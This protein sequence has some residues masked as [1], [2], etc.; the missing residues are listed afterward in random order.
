M[1]MAITDETNEALPI[2]GN[3]KTERWLHRVDAICSHWGDYINPILVKETRQALKSRQ[4]VFTFSLLLFAALAWTI[5][6]SLSL[7]PNIYTSPSAARML[8]G[9]Y[10]VLAIPML[11]VVPLA[12]YRSLEVEIDDGTLE[13]LT[14][15]TLSPRQIVQGKLGS[16]SLQM[17]LYFVALFPC[18]AYAYTLRGIDL[19]TVGLL[20][21]IL[22]VS[23]LF[24]TSIA[25]SMAPQA[26]SRSGRITTLL[27]V[28]GL[29]ILAEYAVGALCVTL[30]IY[31]NPLPLDATVYTTVAV[32]LVAFAIGNLMMTAAAA[33]LTPESEN[34]STKL[35]LALVWLTMTVIGV[36]AYAVW[37]FDRDS[38]P[39]ILIASV[40]LV[41]CWVI[42]GSLL[43]SESPA[44]TP[45]V[46]RELPGSFLARMLLTWLTPG[47]TT[48]LVFA[49]ICIIVVGGAISI[50][51]HVSE[52]RA[53]ASVVFGI[54]SNGI[55]T[56]ISLMCAYL[57]GY[58]IAAR[59]VVAAVRINNNPRVEIGLAALTVLGL[60]GVLAPYSLELHYNDYRPYSYS[61]WQVTNWAWTLME[62]MS[63]R[64]LVVEWYLI[65]G[66]VSLGLLG[67]VLAAGSR[68]LPSRIATPEKVKQELG[69]H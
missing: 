56:V 58:L 32:I 16:A 4:F 37:A 38:A 26:I 3:S 17:M 21:L 15:S 43:V 62:A 10:V 25:L 27:M 66:V 59:W 19:P 6:G 65:M 54:Q 36:T 50:L 49:A 33:Q 69:L 44:I 45:R 12:A 22:L 8:I 63:Q 13:L 20:L 23:G 11:L 35:R 34:R 24:L 52:S 55:D 7:M 41:P 30:I 14:I 48:G 61:T 60:L 64:P 29:V 39:I 67:S 5:A 31:G 42:A 18:V 40:I 57:I 47:P 51:I 1:T 68:T 46:K 9:Y 53:G 28:L 2:G